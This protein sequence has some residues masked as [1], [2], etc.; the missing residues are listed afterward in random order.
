M[1]MT[2]PVNF[3]QMDSLIKLSKLNSLSDD[4]SNFKKTCLFFCLLMSTDYKLQVYLKK[5]L[6][7]ESDLLT[8]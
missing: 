5:S 6:K 7:L 2:I 4:W 8:I 3:S 1:M